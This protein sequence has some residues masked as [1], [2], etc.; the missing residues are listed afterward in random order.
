[1]N[2]DMNLLPLF[3][4]VA[5]EANFRA[6]ADRL[7]VTRSAVSQGIRRL[8]DGIGA[9]LVTRTTRSV[10]L[11]EAEHGVGEA[12]LLVARDDLARFLERPGFAV[13]GCR[14][15]FGVEIDRAGSRHD[16]GPGRQMC[17]RGWRNPP[18]LFGTP[19]SVNV[20][21]RF[22]LWRAAWMPRFRLAEPERSNGQAEHP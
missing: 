17:R 1:M 9:T 2:I 14:E 11:T 20:T 12:G 8:E 7:G 21:R 10:R 22:R 5:E 6:A 3:Q 16:T 18:A 13:G 15:Q 4:A 19:G